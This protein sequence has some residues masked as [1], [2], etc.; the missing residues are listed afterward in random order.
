MRGPSGTGEHA[1]PPDHDDLRCDDPREQQTDA[2]D[3][4]LRQEQDEI[5]VNGYLFRATSHRTE[6]DERSCCP[7]TPSRRWATARKRSIPAFQTANRVAF[8]SALP[9]AL[10]YLCVRSALTP[11]LIDPIATTSMRQDR[12]HIRPDQL[13]G[14]VASYTGSQPFQPRPGWSWRRG[15]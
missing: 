12:D 4:S 14:G 2:N 11:D 1:M 13:T 5:V 7:Q 9:T 10:K 3:P 15:R 8:V 6:D